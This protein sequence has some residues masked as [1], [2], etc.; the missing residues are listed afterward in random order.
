ML[1]LA[2][3][4]STPQS[5]V[6]L[7]TEQG[8]IASMTFS[9]GRGHSE[10]VTPAIDR[11]LR[12]TELEPSQISG[13]A[14]GLGPGL[15]T[16]LRVGVATGRAMAQVLRVPVV[17]IPSLDV[18]AFALRHARSRIGAAIDGKRGQVFF[19]FYRPAPG[20]VTRESDYQVGPP[21]RMVAELEAS[22]EEA[23]LVGNG[24]LLYRRQLQEAGARLEFGS[25]SLAFP[26][27]SSL[28]ELS[29][30]RFQREETERPEH[31]VPLYV[32]KSD[33]EINWVGR[34]RSA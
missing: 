5:S 31:V 16:G 11:L 15:F 28:L 26:V 23:V 24:A 9:W 20:G 18:L 25:V 14:V 21:E 17:G 12:W 6:A 22:G 10:I 30:P 7:G 33:A 32:R 3:E 2:L 27:A 1:V 4:T 29:V 19:A 13:V 8:I 34:A